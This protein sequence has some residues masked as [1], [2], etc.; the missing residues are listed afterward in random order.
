MFKPF[1][2]RTL[3]VSGAALPTHGIEGL[4]VL[5]PVRLTGTETLGK[6]FEYTLLLKTPDDQAFSPS[7][8]ANVELDKL[9]GTE[10]TVSIELEG[11][12]RFI[13]GLPGDTGRGNVGAG[14]REITGLVTSARLL[15]EEGRAIVYEMVLRP[16]L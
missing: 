5:T 3:A 10:V 12:G 13:P 9:I 2:S 7:V 6:L 15:R 11:K 1:Q 8:A 14:T 4:P 16:W